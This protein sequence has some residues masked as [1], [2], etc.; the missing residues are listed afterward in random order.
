MPLHDPWRWPTGQD[1]DPRCG[2]TSFR[3]SLER[4]VANLGRGFWMIFWLKKTCLDIC[5]DR[6]VCISLPMFVDLFLRIFQLRYPQFQAEAVHRLFMEPMNCGWSVLFWLVW[7]SP[8]EN[9]QQLPT[10]W[11]IPSHTTKE[12]EVRGSWKFIV[13]V[14][15]I[16]I[17]IS[18]HT[19]HCVIWWFIT[20]YLH[21]FTIRYIY[22]K[23]IPLLFF[24][25]RSMFSDFWLCPKRMKKAWSPSNPSTWRRTA[26]CHQKWPCQSG[27][28]PTGT[29]TLDLTYHPT[30]AMENQK[31]KKKKRPTFT[32][33]I[34][35]L[36]ML[37]PTCPN[38]YAVS[39]P[40]HKAGTDGHAIIADQWLSQL[41]RQE[42]DTSLIHGLIK[43]T[44]LF[45]WFQVKPLSLVGM[46]VSDPVPVLKDLIYLML[47]EGFLDWVENQVIMVPILST[48]SY[49]FRT[50][51]KK[52]SI[53][54]S[55]LQGE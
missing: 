4:R 49:I 37:Y 39:P 17:T 36:Y 20:G 52:Y 12:D 54:T 16:S 22:S 31:L 7:Q 23:W 13:I 14:H 9:P 24:A 40:H 5:W 38:I 27:K 30:D 53:L 41:Q 26:T 25:C 55:Q 6:R 10:F 32:N 42:K 21:V 3:G 50:V 46:M 15:T 34:S 1:F 29:T 11:L 35:S 18:K 43:Q 19:A 47:T 44:P 33:Q 48:T 51:L 8:F 2:S 28:G 45:S